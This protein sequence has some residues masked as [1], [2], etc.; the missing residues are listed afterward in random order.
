M[1]NSLN[2]FKEL[3]ICFAVKY[4]NILKYENSVTIM[5]KKKKKKD[6]FQTHKAVEQTSQKLV[7]WSMIK[8]QSIWK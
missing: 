5:A 7:Q 8:L 6:D 3:Y 4:V 2:V 1:S